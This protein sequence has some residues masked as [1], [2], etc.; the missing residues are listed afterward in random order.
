MKHLKHQNKTKWKVLWK[1]AKHANK[2]KIA[3]ILN[4]K[5]LK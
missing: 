3:G 4:K 1:Q 5:T 2:K